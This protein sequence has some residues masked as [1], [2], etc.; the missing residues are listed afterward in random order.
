MISYQK[1]QYVFLIKQI[2][3]IATRKP[4]HIQCEL[5]LEEQHLNRNGKI[6]DDQFI[7]LYRDFSILKILYMGE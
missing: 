1:N 4:G 3:V 7:P 5:D 6:L 2:R